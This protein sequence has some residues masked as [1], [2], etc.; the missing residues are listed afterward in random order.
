M[1]VLLDVET[2]SNACD[3]SVLCCKLKTGLALARR[4]LMDVGGLVVHWNM[5]GSKF[6]S[7]LRSLSMVL[8]VTLSLS[9]PWNLAV[10]IRVRIFSCSPE[11]VSIES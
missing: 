11:N 5:N 9:M 1:L 10:G 7:S 8:I 2:K 6:G 4:S 3:V